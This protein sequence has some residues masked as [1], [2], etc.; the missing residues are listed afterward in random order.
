MIM[1]G[2]FLRDMTEAKAFLPDKKDSGQMSVFLKQ[3]G[4]QT[5][6]GADSFRAVPVHVMAT[7]LSVET[8]AKEAA[9]TAEMAAATVADDHSAG[10]QSP[11]QSEP[12]APTEPQIETTPSALRPAIQDNT[13]PSA[14]QLETARAEG[15]AAALAELD[16]ERQTV[17]MAATALASALERLANP[18]AAQ[19]AALSTALDQAVARMAADRAGQVID[20]TPEPFVRRI[21]A[22]AARVS[23]GLGAVTLHLHPSDLEA[24]RAVFDQACSGDLAALARARLVADAGLS[25]GDIDLRTATLHIED[26][27]L[28]AAP[29]ETELHDAG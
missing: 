23:T 11:T 17:A 3:S 18:S 2:S 12:A 9:A 1:D 20:A 8:A 28:A 10:T 29:S 15:R 19:V 5:P 27:I 16:S 6:Q 13:T 7:D 24:V 26:L 22:L 25:R 4:L 14:Q 21:A